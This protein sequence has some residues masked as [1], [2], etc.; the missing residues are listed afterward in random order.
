[1]YNEEKRRK[2]VKQIFLCEAISFWVTDIILIVSKILS[3]LPSE[4]KLAISIAFIFGSIMP[5]LGLILINRKRQN[6]ESQ[7]LINN[8]PKQ[9]KDTPLILKIIISIMILL[10][11]P[12]TVAI[13]LYAF[14]NQG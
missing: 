13:F 1:M 2:F 10:S 8:T 4:F 14:Q 9:K 6:Y 5:I 3:P 11:A 12:F 7:F